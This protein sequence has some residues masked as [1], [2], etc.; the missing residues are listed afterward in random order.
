[1]LV[2]ALACGIPVVAT[3]CG[4][5]EDIVH[6][7]V[8]TLVEPDDPEA[9][10]DGIERILARRAMYDPARLHQQALERYGFASVRRQLMELYNRTTARTNQAAA[11]FYASKS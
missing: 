4:G 5:P 3:R 1:V 9:L 8:G 6:D 10:A 7:G 2:E 11:E